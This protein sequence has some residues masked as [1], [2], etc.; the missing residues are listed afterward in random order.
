[1]EEDISIW[2][3]WPQWTQAIF[4]QTWNALSHRVRVYEGERRKCITQPWSPFIYSAN[5]YWK[6]KK[7]RSWDTYMGDK[8]LSVLL[9]NPWA[10]GRCRSVHRQIIEPSEQ[11]ALHSNFPQHL[12]YLFS[13]TLFRILIPLS[14]GD[15]LCIGTPTPHNSIPSSH[16]TRSVSCKLH[17]AR[18]LSPLAYPP[19]PCKVL[20]K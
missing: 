15:R 4:G 12:L 13:N 1:M 7:A 8:G 11:N 14:S 18:V 16:S 2:V 19:G 9:R 20:S 17:K 10:K 6:P 5:I 3:C